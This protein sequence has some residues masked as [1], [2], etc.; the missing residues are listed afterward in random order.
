MTV[1]VDRASMTTATTGSGTITLG[2]A[3]AGYQTFA[4]AGI[5]NGNTVEYLISDVSNA[6]EIGTGVYTSSGTT[7]TRVLRSSSTGSLLSLSGNA[8]VSIVPT[9]STITNLAPL[10]SPSFTGTVT[11]AGTINTTAGDIN[12]VHA[13]SSGIGQV[14]QSNPNTTASTQSRMEISTG[15][16]NSY[17]LW[18][19]TE[20]GSGSS[21]MQLTCGAGVSQGFIIGSAT[22]SAPLNFYQGV[23]QRFSVDV[24]G[25]LN[26]VSNLIYF[27]TTPIAAPTYTTRSAGTKIVL[28]DQLTSTTADFALGMSGSTMWQSVPNSSTQF[29]WYAGT[30]VIGTLTGVGAFTVTG[31][32]ATNSGSMF[33]GT[34]T[35][36]TASIALNA[37]AGNFRTVSAYT[38]GAA[39]WLFGADTT[40]ETGSN[41][42]S[43]FSIYSFTDAGVSNGA[44]FSISRATGSV[45]INDGLSLGSTAG[46]ST[47]DLS[48][49]IA[50]WGT[51]FGFNVTSSA[52]NYTVPT[53]SQ[54]YFN[55]A[56]TAVLSIASGAV[57]VSG[58]LNSTG[59]MSI[60]TNTAIYAGLY[61]N[62]LAGDYK[63][64]QFY[65]G[66]LGRWSVYS[67]NQTE[68]GSNAGSGF[69]INAFSDA[70]AYLSTPLYITRASGL[71][72]MANGLSVTGGNLS[73][74]N[75]LT[76]SGL[77]TAS[78][79]L[80]LGVSN[81]ASQGTI[82]IGTAG[83]YLSSNTAYTSSFVYLTTGFA[84]YFRADGLTTDVV[85]LNVAPSGTAG[86][87]LAAVQAFSASQTGLMTFPNGI[88][89]TGGNASITNALNVSGTITGL[90]V[91]AAYTGN[92]SVGLYNGS[93]SAT[94]YISF[95]NPA[96][97]RQGYIG[98]GGAGGVLALET[99]NGTTGYAV[100]GTFSVAGTT[101]LTGSLSTSG[102]ITV[103]SNTATNPYLYIDAA[104]AMPRNIVFQTAGLSRWAIFTDTTTESGSN[105]G[106]N[107]FIG[108]F[109]DAGA[110]NLNCL[111]INRATSCVSFP[112]ILYANAG[113]AI[114]NGI[115]F[116]SLV[117]A[118]NTD[119]SK[120][121]NL[122]GGTYGFNITSN[123]LN[124]VVGSGAAHNFVLN[125]TSI[126]TISSTGVSVIGTLS[127]SGNLTVGSNTASNPFLTINGAAATQRVISFDTAGLQRWFVATSN[128]AE[129]GSNVGSDFF[130]ER[131]TDAGV[132]IDTPF[133][134]TRSTGLIAISDGLTVYGAG[135]TGTAISATTLSATGTVSGA[136]FTNLLSPYA[137]L[138]GA[139]F[140]GAIT[141]TGVGVP[142]VLNNTAGGYRMLE[143]A[144]ANVVRWEM[145]VGNDA[146]SGSNAG[147]TFNITAFGDGGAYIAS[148][149]SITRSSGLTSINNGLTVSG[150]T[151]L[152]GATTV[153]GYLTTTGRFTIN[154]GAST[155][156]DV[157]VTTGGSSRWVFG[158]DAET[159]SGSNAGSNWY[160]QAFSD[161]AAYLSQPLLISRASGLVTMAN[162][163][164][165]SPISGSTGSFTTLSAS[166]TVSGAGFTALLS[167]YQQ[168]YQVPGTSGSAQWVLLGTYTPITNGTG[169]HI[170]LRFTL[171]NGYNANYTQNTEATIF[172]KTSNGASVDANGFAGDCHWNQYGHGLALVNVKWV[173][174][175]A[176]TAATN[177]KLYVSL[178]SNTGAYSTYVVTT[179]IQGAWANAGTLGQT[180]PGVGSSTVSIGVYD[181][182]VTATAINLNG[183]VNSSPIDITD[184]ST[185]SSGSLIVSAVNSA[186]GVNIALFGNG[187]TTP[188][189]YLRAAGGTFQIMSSAYS[190]I[191]GL[192]DAG[193]MN[194]GGIT[195]TPIGATP[196]TGAFTT[197]SASGIISGTGFTNLLSPYALTS[198]LSA[199]LTTATAA[200][201]YYLQTNP[202]GYQTAANVTSTLGAY[203]PLSGGTLTGLVTGVGFTNTGAFRAVQGIP[204]S[205]A[206]TLG[207]GFAAD[208]DTGLFSPIVGV[209]GAANGIVS[210]FGNSV[211][212]LRG[213]ATGV[214]I[215]GTLS[216]AGTVSGTGFTNL[217]SPYALSSALSSYLTTATAASTYYLQ[218][219]PSGYIS[220]ITSGNVITALGFTPYNATNPSGYQTAANVTSTLGSYLTTASAAGTYYLQTNPS[221]YQTAANVTSTLGSYLTT[222]TAASTYYLQTNPAGYQTAANVTTALTTLTTGAAENYGRNI[223]L[224]GRINV[225]QRGTGP[226]TVTGYYTADRWQMSVVGDT[227]SASVISL[228][229]ATIVGDESAAAS[230]QVVVTG[231]A[232]AGNYTQIVQ[233]TLDAK[234]TSN[235]TV[236][237]SFWAKGSAALNVGVYLAQLFGTGGSPSTG[238]V[239]APHTFAVTTTW[240]RYSCSFTVPST[241]GETFGTNNDSSLVVGIGLS[242]GS[243]FASQLGVGVQSGT[244]DFWGLQLEIGSTV[245]ALESRST[246]DELLR[247]QYFYALGQIYVSGYG[248]AGAGI[249]ASST[250]PRTMR[251]IPTVAV[252][253]SVYNN[254]NTFTFQ[255]NNWLIAAFGLVTA[256]GTY[257]LNITYNASADL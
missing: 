85:S 176:G 15:T 19:I 150:T 25:Y 257:S 209:G 111:S 180:D 115:S 251:A 2:S 195:N 105:A 168:A 69:G 106:C 114:I 28:Y 47:T 66:G 26:L 132:Y 101:S 131:F 250:Y 162:G 140:T 109:T 244:F 18:T 194:L 107:F 38:A 232:S 67:D 172:F 221:G 31:A 61:L 6:W 17:G 4:V 210:L 220:S 242:S 103:G 68:A 202:S 24:N 27:G 71:V 84:W 119:L 23:T 70:G 235:K 110:Y 116:G 190:V 72:A 222:A 229:P 9:A 227:F 121:I 241:S 92:G 205:D 200:S 5:V 136:G 223:L 58:T 171:S 233:N 163:I 78:G 157:Y 164:T 147:A 165:S 155:A 143:F 99:E 40:A 211:E 3:I 183:Q 218:T 169:D 76:V 89:V 135:I 122:W 198:A 120:H 93:T 201:T 86:A 39:R 32:L 73:V 7:L 35:S 104:A 185:N 204:P 20:S 63:I 174:N 80:L 8:F 178:S 49:G 95:F 189:K 113:I 214:T 246:D 203:L 82:N 207:Y 240:T 126:E 51:T 81:T 179:S 193:V 238:V 199:Y 133:V 52:L 234:R 129:G 128:T 13:I 91:S 22:T 236:T 53:G 217:L 145:G 153:G 45:F 146:E 230:L 237:F 64:I 137:P 182:T 56:G 144:T 141:I 79:Q 177:Y 34:A 102:N 196:S 170:L 37:T 100:S 118:S 41:A 248:A 90:T 245:T 186:S 208:G 57:T 88:S 252:T 54:H 215:Y 160:L 36:T 44:V 130:I 158:C 256:I 48:H 188:N 134:I 191:V 96:G 231:G 123:T 65:T 255:V 77:L 225:Q 197:L 87:T 21:L 224:N 249:I 16:S 14:S 154:G 151:T 97:V 50:L 247:C 127:S 239:I 216:V 148:P 187:S 43:N 156:R 138:A 161:S 166:S 181:F 42:G 243:T 228:P 212:I 152:S 60:G 112:Q 33:V 192:T 46:A 59:N 254:C 11:S 10:A 167:P 206:A 175:A 226:W 253:S 12:S 125:G 74:S 124:Y 173:G 55:I 62:A 159:E 213:I 219:N 139:T 94:G 184:S 83:S 149:L 98:F 108:S 142:I 75:G 117:G 1:Y 30:S 29:Q